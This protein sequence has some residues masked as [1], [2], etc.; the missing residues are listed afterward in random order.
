MMMRLEFNSMIVASSRLGR[1]I[2]TMLRLSIASLLALYFALPVL[3][4]YPGSQELVGRWTAT[5]EWTDGNGGA[6]TESPSFEI[7]MDQGVLVANSIRRDGTPGA[8][9]KINADG[10][11]VHLYRFLTLD[12]GEHLIWKLELQ[13]DKLVGT[14][15]ALHDRPSKWIYD[16]E[17]EVAM[18][19]AK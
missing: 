17:L 9:L 13:N 8:E 11:K 7:K 6:H 14:Y 1:A 10:P 3:S 18:A 16:R 2:P 12:D 4:Q 5:V 19:K 15:S